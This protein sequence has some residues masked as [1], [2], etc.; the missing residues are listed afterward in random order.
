MDG[1]ADGWWVDGWVGGWMGGW[2][3]GWVDGWVGGWMGR[4]MVVGCIRNVGT[5]QY[6]LLRTSRR[7]VAHSVFLWELNSHLRH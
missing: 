3:D 4:W 5:S 2:A 7:Q 6:C 1:W